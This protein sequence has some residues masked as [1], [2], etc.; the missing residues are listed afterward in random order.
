LLLRY[1]TRRPILVDLVLTPNEEIRQTYSILAADSDVLTVETDKVNL[2]G[3][4]A[5]LWAK[6]VPLYDMNG[7]AIG[8]IE[9]IRDVT[10]RK[11]IQEALRRS[12]EQY[13]A[14]FDNAGIGI[15]LLDEHGGI[16]KANKAL[17]NILGYPE[18][19]LRQR[20]FLD[21]TYPDDREISKQHLEALIAG[22]IDSYRLEKRYVRKDGGIVWVDL[23]SC[24]I[25]DAKGGHA[26]V[27]AVIEDISKRKRSEEVQRRLA[28]AVEQAAEAV[29][30]TDPGGTIQYVNPAFERITGY[31]PKEMMGEKPKILKS[32]EHDQ[33]FY[34]NI[35]ETITSGKPWTGRFINKRKD[36]SLYHE[37]STISPVLDS[38]G[39]IM[40]FVA[41]K[42]DITEQLE[43]SRQLLQAQKMEAIGTL[44]GG[45]AHDFNNLL[46]VTLGYSELLLA[47]KKKDDPEYAD[48]SRMFEAAKSGAEL[49]QRLL[50][51]SRKVEPKTILLNLNRRIL[52]VEKLLR[53]TIPKMIDIELDL[54]D[55][56][57]D[58]DADPTQMEQVLMNLA[59][60][61]RDAMQDKGTLTVRTRNVTLDEEYCRTHAEAKPGEYVLLTVS[62]TGDGMDK[63]TID[64]IF[65][66]FYTTK[67]SGRGTGLGLA[68][69]YGIVEQHGGHI[70]CESEVGHG[71]T[72]EV[73]FPAIES[74]VEPELD[75]TGVMPA[76]GTETILLVDDEEFVRDL[77]ARILS[78]AGYNVLTATNGKEG[79]DLFEKEQ[80]QIS[81]VI[82][83]L[84]MP[85]MGGKECLKELY[86][87]D[88]QLKVLIASGLADPSIKEPVEMETRGFVSKPFR[89]TELLRQVRKVLDE[90]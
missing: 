16:V 47:E 12:E 36:G 35:W 76:F 83:D 56:L 55:D 2:S 66:P 25:R 3:K 8:A 10:E 78:I 22:E 80:T 75:K 49:V 63:A 74:Q 86:K 57:A 45:V 54:S 13:R 46:Q 18:E 70:T 88:P 73:Y 41:V 11:Q 24:T 19:E 84:I 33:S 85:E 68:M 31:S 21:I 27:V 62:D 39:K 64:R 4:N 82:L 53:R 6:A 1:G 77:G 26:G 65:E 23:W 9:S 43:L 61:A 29:V 48:L 89:M 50:T 69:V 71:T 34:K 67:E 15:D 58:I 87:I 7:A 44:A 90:S 20:S 14:V 28:K 79:L 37:D 51:F 32:G 60:N 38:N 30:I 81:L 42:R 72:F 17:L 59:V 5:V 52:Q 40:N